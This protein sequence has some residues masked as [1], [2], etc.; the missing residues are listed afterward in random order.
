VA[1]TAC[2]GDFGTAGERRFVRSVEVKNKISKKLKNIF[3]KVYN[4]YIYVCIFA[5]TKT[6]KNN[7]NQTH[8]DTKTTLPTCDNQISKKD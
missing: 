2:W 7:L 3:K 4:I 1:D 6:E 8:H 5:Y